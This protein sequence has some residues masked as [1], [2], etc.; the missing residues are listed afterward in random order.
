MIMNVVSPVPD[1]LLRRDICTG[2]SSACKDITPRYLHDSLS[3]L[4]FFVQV[5]CQWSS[6][7]S[8]HLNCH[9]P[10]FATLLYL[11]YLFTQFFVFFLHGIYHFLITLN[12]FLMSC[13]YCWFPTLDIKLH[14][15]WHFCLLCLW[16]HLQLLRQKLAE[17]R[18]LRSIF[19]EMNE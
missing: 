5:S 19:K 1:T 13:V 6:L 4:H 2:S 15:S 10:F 14:K 9:C 11:L 3:H 17:S 12:I 8:P 18:T 16:L 7:S